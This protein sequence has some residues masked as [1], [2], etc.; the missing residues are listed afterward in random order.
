[1]GLREYP[2]TIISLI[3]VIVL[4]SS[5][6]FFNHLNIQE[7]EYTEAW[8]EAV[9]I[10]KI[11]TS[12]KSLIS[13]YKGNI[14]TVNTSSP[15]IVNY[16]ILNS[17]G[18][19]IKSGKSNLINFNNIKVDN[20]KLISNKLFY[21]YKNKLYVSEFQKE[22]GFS[23]SKNI[24]SNIID[25]TAH[26]SDKGITITSVSEDTIEVYLL[27]DSINRI[28]KVDNDLGVEKAYYRQVNGVDSLYCIST[29]NYDIQ[30]VLV[31]SL[32]G[33]NK[34]NIFK[35]E[36]VNKYSGYNINEL[37][38]DYIDNNVIITYVVN[39]NNQGY[40]SNN[41]KYNFFDIENFENEK[42][43]FEN[44]KYDISRIGLDIDTYIDSNKLHI[45][46]SGKNIKNKYT[47]TSDIFEIIVNQ[48][49][50]IEKS[51]FISTTQK[52][53][54]NVKLINKGNET[55][56]IFDEI[57]S[58]GYITSLISNNEQFLSNETITKDDYID[59]LYK[60]STS[61]L[62][63]L[64]YSFLRGFIILLFMLIPFWGIYL[65]IKNKRIESE[66]IKSAIVILAYIIL[67]LLLFE[68]LYFKL[69]KQ[70]QFYPDILYTN[71]YRI[72]APLIINIV[73]LIVVVIF[74]RESDKN[75]KEYTYVVF[76]TFF[77]ILD[78]Y[79]SNIVHSP[80]SFIGK[81]IKF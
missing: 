4:F 7:L 10:N 65:F 31:M 68:F 14:I 59:A 53:S 63:A 16:S 5:I 42:Y 45:V 32:N 19:S 46:G 52:Y 2:K 71:I 67:N 9:K 36:E 48:K 72:I 28:F 64:G 80:F 33:K 12:D 79:L 66:K 73:S 13:N 26:K 81:L 21:I 24:L 20:I 49:G 44:K 58:E 38:I 25:F 11:S 37:N 15:N 30:K 34:G 6:H 60:S 39:L 3:L 27:G 70:V 41:I 75:N 55:Y 23:K 35:I 8:G 78:V 69:V 57:I 74:Y 50:E 17:N 40:S 18:Q 56:V 1:M 76:S 47:D 51:E 61:P 29:E 77:I 22:E 43:S 62:I 54:K